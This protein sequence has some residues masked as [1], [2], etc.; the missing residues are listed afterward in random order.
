LI[1]HWQKEGN[2][3]EKILS[4]SGRKEVFWRDREIKEGSLAVRKWKDV[5]VS[6][7]TL[8]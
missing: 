4:K 3:I 5:I 8:F 7:Y 2:K 6:R 1:L